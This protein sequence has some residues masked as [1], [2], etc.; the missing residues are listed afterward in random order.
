MRVLVTGNNGYIG[1]VLCQ[2]LLKDNFSPIGVDT[3]FYSNGKFF[4]FGY[5]IKQINKDIRLIT[6]EEL[7]G[8][9]AIIHLAALSND[10]IGEI[11]PRLTKEINCQASVDLAKLAKDN[12]VKRFIFSSSCSIYGVS[13]KD[14]IDE[15]G[16]LNPLTEYARSKIE[17]EREVAKIADNN[18]SPVF[19]R[20]ATVYG[21]SPMFRADLVLNNLAAWAYT[22]KNINIMSDGT[23]WRPL[24]H[25]EDICNA[26]IAT[27]KAPRELI[28]NQIFNVG[29]EHENYQI[30]QIAATINRIMP[31]C[32][33]KYT[34]EHGK[35]SRSY[36]VDFS[37]FKNVLGEYCKF[38]WNIEKGTEQLMNYFK[39]N[40]FNKELFLGDKFIRINRIK[41]LISE[42][43]LDENLFW[44]KGEKND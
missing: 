2:K 13:D 19:L 23:P 8:I 14:M 29:Q 31:E 4:D 7:N 37:K 44:K 24:I 39:K 9:D 16:D 20:N 43:R 33:I 12:K 5:T 27:L 17:T 38:S 11:N 35:D 30:K 3:N 42:N 40:N 34:G 28:H 10:P 1:S 15:C 18:F 21:V 6:I 22:T 32:K 41:R 36:K 25:V 26:F